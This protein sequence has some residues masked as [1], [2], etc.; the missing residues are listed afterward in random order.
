MSGTTTSLPTS[1]PRV[2]QGARPRQRA[3]DDHKDAVPRPQGRQRLRRV[4]VWWWHRDLPPHT[5]PEN[6]SEVMIMKR[7]MTGEL[8]TQDGPAPRAVG[9]AVCRI[10]PPGSE[11]SADGGPC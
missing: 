5:H 4:E 10:C 3:G 1:T 9:P 8:A 6:K 2:F 7:T 11:E